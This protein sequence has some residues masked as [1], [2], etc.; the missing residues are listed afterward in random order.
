MRG[1]QL[2]L[3]LLLLIVV[4][5]ACHFQ[6]AQL[7][8]FL[9]YGVTRFVARQGCPYELWEQ[10]RGA[11]DVETDSLR[12][13]QYLEHAAHPTMLASA[14]AVAVLYPLTHQPRVVPWHA[15]VRDVLSSTH[16][17]R[18]AGQKWLNLTTVHWYKATR[19]TYNTASTLLDEE[20][21]KKEMANL[22]ELV[23]VRRPRLKPFGLLSGASQRRSWIDG[24]A[25]KL[26]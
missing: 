11:M 10:R 22:R 1:G 5:G 21:I 17:P 3:L 14:C 20:P 4:L 2:L 7:C 6:G 16:L 19:E 15:T 12:S 24:G 23:K 25:L 18:S 13:Q 26:T 8:L 9:G